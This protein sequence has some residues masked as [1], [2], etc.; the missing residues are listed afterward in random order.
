MFLLIFFILIVSINITLSF[1]SENIGDLSHSIQKSYGPS[2]NIKGWINISLEGESADSLFKTNG[3]STSL[4]NLLKTDINK[5]I[6]YTCSPL[7]CETDY[8]SSN[9]E[10]MKNFDLD[11]NNYTIFGFELTGNIISVN[12]INLFLSIEIYLP[13]S[14]IIN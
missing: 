2:E 7:N 4:I 6:E 5:D 1:S 9:P 13:T 14:V 3:D 8:S 11:Q 10:T 12:S